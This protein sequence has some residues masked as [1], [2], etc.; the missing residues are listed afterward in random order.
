MVAVPIDA[1]EK[2]QEGMQDHELKPDI[3]RKGEAK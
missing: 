2:S 1:W 3:Y